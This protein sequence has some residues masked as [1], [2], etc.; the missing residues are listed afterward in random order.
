MRFFKRRSIWAVLFGIVLGVGVVYMFTPLGGTAAPAKGY[1]RPFPFPH[2]YWAKTDEFY[3]FSSGGTA[4]GVFVYGIPSMKYLSTI[5]VF[6][7]DSA[8][9]W[10]P[11]NPKVKAMLT[12][13][14]TGRF[15][16]QGDTHHTNMSQTDAMYDGR[17]LFI[18]DKVAPRI[19]RINLK[20]FRTEEVHYIP[21][22][23]S[24]HGL[25]I[26]P[27]SEYLFANAE[28]R[29]PIPRAEIK[30]PK[31]YN[32]VLAAVKV[33]PKTGK[34][35]DAWQIIVPGNLDMNE[36]GRG[37]SDGWVVADIYNLEEAVDTLG[38]F[39]F[40]YDAAI[41][42]NWRM[43]EK[44]VKEGKAK[45]IGGV[46]T[47]MATDVPGMAYLVPVPRN[48]HGID[49]SPDG[50][51]IVSNGKATK[52]ISIIDFKKF[53]EAIKDPKN[54]VGKSRGA[55]PGVP[56]VKR[57]AVLAAEVPGGLGPLHTEFDDKG[58]GYTSIFADSVITRW[59]LGEP[60]FTG[61]KAWK[62][63]EKIPV[64]YSVGH[65]A[66]AGGKTRKPYGKYLISMNKLTKDTFL[67][68]G[69]L[70]PENHELF[71]ISTVPAKRI[72]QMPIPP[73]PHYVQMLPV[74]MVKPLEV[75]KLDPKQEGVTL[76]ATDSRI[77]YDKDKKIA[78]VYMTAVR[79]VYGL[80]SFEVPLGWKVV[81]YLTNLEETPDITH[82]FAVTEHDIDVA[83]DPGEV[84]KIEFMAGKPG[85]YWYFCTW[86][87]SE[88]HL[89][90]AGRMIVK[91]AS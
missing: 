43:A 4:G 62:V 75:Y 5:P 66:V 65:L 79:P 59:T 53:L 78:T 7:I 3:A 17:W 26:T 32:S 21:N 58:Y 48:P 64:H 50:R 2:R 42:M 72:D 45:T 47:I 6:S 16:T 57:E 88:L 76:R 90:M 56:I 87:C 34:M 37:I 85:V 19:G 84:T 15:L 61:D 30:E 69:P 89:E 31:D 8:W 18:N 74:K 81:V 1:E 68:V 25:A 54:I 28:F 36:A 23:T 51:Y 77:V 22:M 83:M 41:Y 13:P 38:M 14:R 60:W 12:D 63:V 44:A 70:R 49:V 20:T 9:N 24:I 10:R 73:E 35:S 82:G 11:E 39:K 91:P 86:F 80:P 40:D 67:P 55:V 52:K 46:P 29:V 27:N 71:D 33:D